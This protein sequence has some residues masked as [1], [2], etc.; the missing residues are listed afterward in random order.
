M[1]IRPR[2]K[3]VFQVQGSPSKFRKSKKTQA[4]MDTMKTIKAGGKRKKKEFREHTV[5]VW[6]KVK[7]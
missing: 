6:E 4:L 5:N 3:K 2:V 1:L 7:Q